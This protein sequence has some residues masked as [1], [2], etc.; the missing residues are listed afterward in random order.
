LI[1]LE[2]EENLMSVEEK[3]KKII[4]EKLSVEMEELVPEA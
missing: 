1:R 2:K 3:V 4:T